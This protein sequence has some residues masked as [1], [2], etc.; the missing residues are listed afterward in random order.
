MK[1]KLSMDE[2]DVNPKYII[3]GKDGWHPISDEVVLQYKNYSDHDE[4]NV[5]ILERDIRWPDRD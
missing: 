2:K 3:I 1:F 4:P 5:V